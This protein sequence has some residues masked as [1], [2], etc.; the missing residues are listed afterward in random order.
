MKGSGPRRL[1]FQVFEAV[2]ERRALGPRRLGML[3]FSVWVDDL[4]RTFSQLAGTRE[5]PDL[6]RWLAKTLGVAGSPERRTGWV[7]NV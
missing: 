5:M 6:D 3:N 7:M 4:D 1:V 2:L